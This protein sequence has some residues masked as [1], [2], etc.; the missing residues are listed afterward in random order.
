MPDKARFNGCKPELIDIDGVRCVVV[1][2]PATAAN[3]QVFADLPFV[4]DEDRITA[5]ELIAQYTRIIPGTL[6]KVDRYR[7]WSD[8]AYGFSDDHPLVATDGRLKRVL[9]RYTQTSEEEVDAVEEVEVDYI[10]FRPVKNVDTIDRVIEFPKSLDEM[11]TSEK[12]LARRGKVFTKTIKVTDT[13]VSTRI[14]RIPSSKTLKRTVKR[15]VKS[16]ARM[17]R[18]AS[19]FD[20]SVI[21]KFPMFSQQILGAWAWTTC[22]KVALWYDMRV[23]KTATAIAGIKTFMANDEIDVAIV[24]CPVSNM[25]DPWVNELLG[26]GL[27]VLVLDGTRDDDDQNLRAMDYDVIVVNYDRLHG[28]GNRLPLM[29]E[30]FGTKW[31]RV[32]VV[33]DETALIKTPGIGATVGC[34]EI[35]RMCDR[36]CLLNGTPLGNS[37]IDLWS[38]VKVIDPWGVVL[39][40]TIELFCSTYLE[41]AGN[42]EWSVPAGAYE[43]LVFEEF[44]SKLCI[45]YIRG[46]SDQFKGKDKQYRYHTILPSQEMVDYIAQVSAGYNNHTGDDDEDGTEVPSN[47]LAILSFMRM[48]TSSL[49]KQKVGERVMPNGKAVNVYRNLRMARDPK[50][51][52]IRTHAAA[53]PDV[54]IIVFLEHNEHE[55]WLKEILDQDGV[56]WNSCSPR[57]EKRNKRVIAPS[58]PLRIAK[59]LNE[60]FGIGAFIPNGADHDAVS[61]APFDDIDEIVDYLA[62]D[63]SAEMRTVSTSYIPGAAKQR[64]DSLLYMW[65]TG[66]QH[67]DLGTRNEA[68]VAKTQYDRMVERYKNTSKT[69]F[70]ELF[71]YRMVHQPVKPYSSEERSKQVAEFNL[72]GGVFIM[73]TAQ[74]KGISLACRPY[75]AA[76]GLPPITLFGSPTFSFLNFAQASD[77]AVGAKNS[78]NQ[79]APKGKD[80]DSNICTM[81]HALITKGSVDEKVYDALRRKEKLSVKSLGDEKRKGYGSSFGADTLEEFAAQTKFFDFKEMDARRMCRILPHAKLSKTLMANTLKKLSR[82]MDWADIRDQYQ[83]LLENMKDES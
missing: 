20:T 67:P 44:I 17:Y 82:R 23:G 19:I 80:A 65:E 43:Q 52:W 39:P 6:R 57:P 24:V 4:A 29:K 40:T 35:G 45:R 26:E 32:A 75:L 77:R 22:K 79:H 36:V 38:Q 16:S 25:F 83:Y 11:S 60:R 7:V 68:K 30:A 42:G 5:L 55:A 1:A 69:Y 46:E 3:L 12:I 9:E 53:S 63:E 8:A 28:R 61:S 18:E 58:I 78:E 64:M 48:A 54:P 50:I 81:V 34:Q 31:D 74:A 37:P 27:K 51:E 66:H 73:K 49:M 59:R 56:R 21:T 13:F 70:D 71:G 10:A 15:T 62:S 14:D 72:K 47:M 2:V 33:M 76:G 41:P